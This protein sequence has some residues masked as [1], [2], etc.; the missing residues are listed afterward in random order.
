[1]GSN[2][3]LVSILKEGTNRTYHNENG[4]AGHY[5]LLLFLFQPFGKI[6]TNIVPTIIRP[7]VRI[8]GDVHFTL[9][10]HELDQ[11]IIALV[12]VE[13]HLH[14]G[15]HGSSLE[16]APR[17]I[18]LFG[19]FHRNIEILYAENGEQRYH[20]AIMTKTQRGCHISL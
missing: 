2:H 5:L 17:L 4:G 15:S 19:S 7:D 3:S 16:V 20:I 18:D 8:H 14:I 12:L 13:H 6:F 11:H 1:M 10:V 9:V